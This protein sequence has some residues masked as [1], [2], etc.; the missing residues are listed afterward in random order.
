LFDK[1]LKV[2][3]FKQYSSSCTNLA[4]YKEL[5]MQ[6]VTCHPTQVNLPRQT[7]ARQAGTQFTY[8]DR[9]KAELT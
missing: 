3:R 6:C 8:L 4:C 1:P 7:P 9:W 2:K 5:H